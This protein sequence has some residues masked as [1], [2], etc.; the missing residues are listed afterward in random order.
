M[1]NAEGETQGDAPAIPRYSSTPDWDR[2]RANV[3]AL[4]LRNTAKVLW[5]IDELERAWGEPD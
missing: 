5:A 3:H 1:M 4:K 2:L